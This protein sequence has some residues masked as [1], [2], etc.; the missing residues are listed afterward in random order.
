MGAAVSL[1]A[2]RFFSVGE[3]LDSLLTENSC[4]LFFGQL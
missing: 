3:G 2:T 1:I 4:Q